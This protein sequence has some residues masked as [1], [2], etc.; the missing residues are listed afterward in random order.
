ME[1]ITSIG[2]WLATLII[3]D[4][5]LDRCRDHLG[6]ASEKGVRALLKH[7]FSKRNDTAIPE[8]GH[9]ER[10]GREALKEATRALLLGIHA[11]LEPKPPLF[12]AI[13]N[14]FKG[15]TLT[16]QPLI[17]LRH[18]PSREWLKALQKLCNDESSFERLVCKAVPVESNSIARFGRDIDQAI[19]REMHQRFSEWLDREMQNIPGR[20]DFLDD[21]IREG[22]P[23]EQ[24]GRER[25]TLYQTW[26]LFFRKK[27]KDQPEVF[28]ILVADTLAEVAAEVKELHALATQLPSL[29]DFS[30]WLGLRLGALQNWL[31]LQFAGVHE[32]LDDHRKLL[33]AIKE[34]TANRQLPKPTGKPN[35]LSFGSIGV[36]FKGRDADVEKI[37]AALQTKRPLVIH[38]LVGVGKTR[39]MTEYALA[40]ADDY[41]ALLSVGAHSPDALN[42]NLAALYS[43]LALPKQ[44]PTEQGAQCQAVLR[45]LNDNPGWLLLLDN[46]DSMPAAQAVEQLLPRLRTGHAIVTSRV[47]Q[48]SRAVNTLVLEELSP[49]AAVEFLLEATHGARVPAAT[50]N[51]DAKALAK[52]LGNLP[53]A[54]EQAAAYIET[55]HISLETY[56]ARWHERE[57]N[58]HRWFDARIMQYPNSFAVTWDTTFEQLS[59]TAMG[60]LRMLCWLAPDSI[61]RSLLETNE[62]T[63]ILA[64]L[65]AETKTNHSATEDA[66]AELAGCS[67]LKW[68]QD[69]ASFRIHCLVQKVAQDQIASNEKARFL[70]AA[71][72]LV[73]GTLPPGYDEQNYPRFA[74]R[75]MSPESP[76]PNVI[77]ISD[78]ALRLVV[79]LC[80]S[81]LVL[82]LRETN[83]L[84]DAELLIRIQ[85]DL[86][87]KVNEHQSLKVPDN[88]NTLAQILEAQAKHDEAI[89]YRKRA[90]VS[91]RKMLGTLN[92]SISRDL[93][94]LALAL[95]KT[96]NYL[97]AEERVREALEIDEKIGG[98]ESIDVARD[99]NNLAQILVARNQLTEGEKISR[100]ALEIAKQFE[101]TGS[102]KLGIFLF[103][104]ATVLASSGICDDV[105]L[106]MSHAVQNLKYFSCS[107]MHDYANAGAQRLSYQRTLDGLDFDPA[108]FNAMLD[109]ETESFDSFFGTYLAWSS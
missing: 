64:D 89:S 58:V 93:I 24:D 69:F 63:K 17:K 16:A 105:E 3:K 104:L 8:N 29:D 94:D 18:S 76:F 10:A 44:S 59:P 53:L 90:L 109:T 37:H 68:D 5:L 60:L 36:H 107:L 34:Q 27:L 31:A 28:R 20:P 38:G 65:V 4:F 51:A 99:L 46:A 40:R 62:A 80:M 98:S 32:K 26:C 25:V 13:R 52:D 95:K 55:K 70:Q 79:P 15:G 50:D 7:F 33:H 54:L 103:N 30:A 23:V 45:W 81:H 75:W 12:E 19:Q 83:E 2:S 57:A 102:P 66:L 56:R 47:S 42:R 101:E 72:E 87:V 43:G 82:I 100:R 92:K 61:P 71:Y 22:W 91:K 86:D 77:S 21:F 49:S 35:N 41:S 88:L 84:A 73:I 48:W 108:R 39:L 96:G 78:A 1:P 67:L 97:Q 85:I 11:Q 6:E 14:H 9:L 74:R 106:M